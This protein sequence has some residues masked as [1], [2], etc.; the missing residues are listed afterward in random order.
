MFHFPNLLTDIVPIGLG[1]PVL[2]WPGAK[3]FALVAEV[4]EVASVPAARSR[5][6]LW[7]RVQRRRKKISSPCF[8]ASELS[9]DA[10]FFWKVADLKVLEK[11]KNSNFWE[12]KKRFDQVFLKVRFLV[13]VFL[14]AICG[15]VA[16]QISWFPFPTTP[17]SWSIYLVGAQST[18][19]P[20]TSETQLAC[21]S[22]HWK[23]NSVVPKWWKRN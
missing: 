4:V 7:K 18:K 11:K 16:P 10:S 13:L 8:A 20:P 12:K 9:H 6:P 3:V 15:A 5:H 17:S 21:V 1:L 2:L 19:H 22:K 14:D 23:P